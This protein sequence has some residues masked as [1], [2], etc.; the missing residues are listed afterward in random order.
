MRRQQPVQAKGVA[1]GLGKGG[2]L[3]EQ[4]VGEQIASAEREVVT[5]PV[6]A[7]VGRLDECGM[8]NTQ[9]RRRR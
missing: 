7:V 4:R 2:A 5:S 3:V 8:R 1:L 6:S 9:P